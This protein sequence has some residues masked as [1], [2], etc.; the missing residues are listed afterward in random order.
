MIY[1]ITKSNQRIVIL[2]PSN[3]GQLLSGGLV[4]APDKELILAYSPDIQFT[5][6][7]IKRAVA[8]E[9][10][11]GAELSRILEESQKREEVWAG[12]G[13]DNGTGSGPNT[14]EWLSARKG[15]N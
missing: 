11:S 12:N 8:D 15:M 1:L 9:S 2:E 14:V 5:A 10:I 6:D 4:T 13:G 3:V 7:L